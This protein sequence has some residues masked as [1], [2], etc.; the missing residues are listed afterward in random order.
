MCILA[1]YGVATISRLHKMIDL[2]AKEPYKRDY[3]LQKRPV[4]LRSLRIVATPPHTHLRAHTHKGSIRPLCTY[5]VTLQCIRPTQ[6]IVY[7]PLLV[8]T[9][10]KSILLIVQ[11]KYSKSRSGD[12][13]LQNLI[14]RTS[15][16]TLVYYSI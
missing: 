3:I 12:F 11:Y 9:F 16:G 6:T 8:N 5:Y 2:F 13:I 10:Q 1:P 15:C 7:V 14:L 4:I